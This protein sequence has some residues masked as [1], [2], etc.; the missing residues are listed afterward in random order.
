MDNE[1]NGKEKKTFTSLSSVGKWTTGIAVFLVALVACAGFTLT[2]TDV[3]RDFIRTKAIVMAKEMMNIDLTITELTGD[4]F[5]GFTAEGVEVARGGRTLVSARSI[6]ANISYPSIFMG[7][8]GLSVLQLDGVVTSLDQVMELVPASDP[9]KPDEPGHVPIETV[10]VTDSSF[11]T[12]YGTLGIESAKVDI[13]NTQ[14]F[15]VAAAGNISGKEITVT[16]GISKTEG[17]WCAK[18][19]KA[20]LD[21]GT[22]ALD[23]SLYPTADAKIDI[24]SLSLASVSELV[25]TLEKYGLSGTLSGSATVVGSGKEYSSEGSGRLHEAAVQ[26]IPLAELDAKW[27]VR[28]GD[29]RVELGQGKVFDTALS[30]VFTLTTDAKTSEKYM[31]LNADI[32]NLKFADWKGRIEE[33]TGRKIFTKGGITSLSADIKG[34]IKALAGRIDMEPSDITYKEVALKGLRASVQFNGR[35]AGDVDVSA[36]LGGKK[37]AV[38][39]HLSLDEKTPTDLTFSS[40]GLP[41]A[42]ILKSIPQAETSP[43]SAT[44]VV[45]GTCKGPKGKWIVNADATSGQVNIAKVLS[46]KDAAA[47]AS[48]DI[49]AKKLTI[50]SSSCGIYGARVTAKGTADFAADPSKQLDL[51]GTFSGL[52]A[53]NLYTVV[54][55]LQSLEIGANASGKWHVTGAPK[56]PNVTANVDVKRGRFRELD[57]HKLTVSGNYSNYL[58]DLDKIDLVTAGGTGKFTCNVALPQKGVRTSASWKTSGTFSHIKLSAANGVLKRNDEIGGNVSG[59]V[60]VGFD[61]KSGLDWDVDFD[62]KNIS[63][64]G[65]RMDGLKGVVT[66]S[67]KEILVMNTEGTLYKGAF[68]IGGRIEMPPAGKSFSD[69]KIFIEGSIK[70]LNLY[71]VLRRHVPGVRSVQGLVAADIKIFGRASNPGFEVKTRLAPIMSRGFLLPAMD[72]NI[73]GDKSKIVINDAHALL[74]GGMLKAYLHLFSKNNDWYAKFD[75]KGK[76]VDLR[77]FG[78]YIPK[79]YRSMYSGTANLNIKGEGKLSEIEAKGELTS[80][81]VKFMGLSVN[82]ISVPFTFSMKNGVKVAPVTATAWDGQ[83]KGDFSLDMATSNWN[84]GVALDGAQLQKIVSEALPN[85]EGTVTGSGELNIRGKGEMGR[86]HTVKGGGTITLK[87]GEISGFEALETLKKFTGGAPVRFETVQTTFSFANGVLSILPGT[88]ASAPKGDMLYRYMRLDGDIKFPSEDTRRPPRPKAEAVSG[89]NAETPEE[90]REKRPMPMKEDVRDET[91]KEKGRKFAEQDM[92]AADRNKNGALSLFFM[93]KVNIRALNS[94]IG[95]F[96]GLADMGSSYAEDGTMDK[97]EAIGSVLTGMLSG[98]AKNEFRFITFGIG[99]SP[100]EPK[101]FNMKIQRN[102]KGSSAKDSIPASST[103]PD[104]KSLNQEGDTKVKFKFEVPIGPG[105]KGA[106]ANAKG[107]AVEQTLGN[108]INNMDFGS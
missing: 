73:R 96:Q 108:I 15:T 65:V 78:A 76:D 19:V 77:Q 13:E 90:A 67:P 87:N 49:A 59:K 62:A 53:K 36:T 103:D 86:S 24:D 79:E 10:T 102:V 1:N 99:G 46:I 58:L 107:Q 57:I 14:N 28:P 70:K 104:K 84:G 72:I 40:D 82:D 43:V 7:S 94:F 17:S 55:A 38:K 26:G 30:G 60:N 98:L 22:V 85:T 3:L 105:D 23:G 88:Q 8:P 74:R 50:K 32:K 2:R 11:G 92:A 20:G 27:S 97:G 69:A 41:L 12:D 91:L 37:L 5:T 51:E 45:K 9:N 16:G 80:P 35:P 66:G 48:Y 68:N 31:T 25:P 44:I 95:A 89:D 47:S 56:S 63:Y 33:R 100:L 93:G 6:S 29:L 64:A 18:E 101:I 34:P 71:E 42:N 54:P 61:A 21:S 81:N 106:G 75:V 83:I 4:P 39:G 52:D